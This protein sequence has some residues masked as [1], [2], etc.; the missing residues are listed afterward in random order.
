M[1]LPLLLSAGVLAGDPCPIDLSVVEYTPA[2]R[3]RSADL[4]GLSSQRSWF[5]LS[6]RGRNN[7]VHVIGVSP[8]SPAE[9]AGLQV[10]DVLVEAGGGVVSNKAAVDA[11]FDKPINRNSIS[12]TVVRDGRRQQLTLSPG[13]ADPLV[14]ALIQAANKAE[15]RNPH[16]ASVTT[17][18]QAALSLGAFTPERGFR[19]GDAHV[20]LADKFES[21]T[22]VVVRGGKRLL[23]TMPGWNT[24]CAA[25]A[26]TD[27]D[28]LTDA[29]VN[30]LLESV[31]AAYV[32]DRHANP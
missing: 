29:T 2:W 7:N 18:Q 16:L 4:A 27:G 30:R 31:S 28:R 9:R 13:P 10:G 17:D 6:Y 32:Q 15:C 8:H 19:C 26:D 12:L 21:G 1:L 24:V 14:L 25:V 3:D 20:A 23:L 22:L 11:A 5:G